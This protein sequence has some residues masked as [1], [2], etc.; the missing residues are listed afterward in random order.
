M[1]NNLKRKFTLRTAM[2]IA[3][4]AA[5]IASAAIFMGVNAAE[6]DVS[7]SDMS[8]LTEVSSSSV[9]VTRDVKPITTN[10]A[11]D[12]L[13]EPVITMTTAKEIGEEFNLDISGDNVYV[14]YGDGDPVPY[15]DSEKTVKGANIKIYGENIIVLYCY[16]NNLTTL[17]VSQ[18]TALLRLF[19]DDNQLTTLDVSKNTSLTVLNCDRNQLTTLDVS[20]NTSLTGLNCVQNQLTTLDVSKNTSLTVLNCDQNHLS[21]LVVSKNTSLTELTCCENQLT[22]LDVSHDSNLELLFCSENQLTSLDVSHDSN[23]ELLHCSENQ[24][25]SLDVSQ[26]TS[27]TNLYCRGNNL[28]TL[29]VS[30][31]TAL[32]RLFC[33][34]NQLTAIDVSNNIYMDVLIC[35]NNLLTVL[36]VSNNAVLNY[37]DCTHNQLTS[38]D[39]SNNTVMAYLD[40]RFNYLSLENVNNIDGEPFK[41][42]RIFDID[43]NGS[44]WYAPQTHVIPSSVRVGEKINL[45]T[46]Y[47]VDG[48]ITEFTWFDS[49]GNVVTPVSS[50]NGFFTFGN[51]AVGKTLV[52]KMT[53]D[54]LPDFKIDGVIGWENEAYSWGRIQ[55]SGDSRLTTTEVTIEAADTEEPEEPEDNTIPVNDNPFIDHAEHSDDAA[56]TIGDEEAGFTGV[57]LIVSNIENNKKKS[58]LEAI[59]KYAKTFNVEEGNTALYEVSLDA[60]SDAQVKVVAGKIKC[61]IKYPDNLGRQSE[62]YTFKLYHRKADG[63]VEEIPIVC[64]PDGIWFEATDFSPYA[65][66]W[67]AKS[68]GGSPGTGESSAVIWIMSGLCAMSLAAAGIV[69]YRRKKASA[70]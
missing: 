42:R 63:T 39:V 23:L 51:D 9:L 18:N 54:K 11:P 68:S 14:D 60:G 55:I 7:S 53:N 62:K 5:L 16:G 44:Y 15:S 4:S 70:E 25:T 46:I 43:F 59:K 61:R 35:R 36:D 45:S 8:S 31:N 20:K 57:R 56:I 2:L 22:K 12:N 30:Q 66:V 26:N 50:L 40:C 41:S 29:D 37:L 10:E 3:L 48:T 21:T 1:K 19:C 49:Q 27:L 28:T 69:L 6:D 13:G 67:N 65:L 38:L 47:S 33:D 24:L 64:K 32:L 52:C 58:V 17:D 34:D